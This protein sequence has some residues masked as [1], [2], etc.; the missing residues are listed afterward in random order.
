MPSSKYP[1]Q[2]GARVIDKGVRNAIAERE[3]PSH[4]AVRTIDPRVALWNT[5]A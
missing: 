3:G 2:D 4:F 5:I 1:T